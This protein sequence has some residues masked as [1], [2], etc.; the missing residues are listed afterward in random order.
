ME[1]FAEMDS[2]GVGAPLAPGTLVDR[3]YVL[4]EKLGEGG[5]GAVY[6]ATHRARGHVVALKLV[7]GDG[8]REASHIS[9]NT[10]LHKRVG[11]IREFQTLASLHHPNVVRV[12]GYGFDPGLGPYFAMEHL[13]DPETLL[14]AA[15]GASIERKAGL[16]A[17]LLRAIGYL[18]RRGVIHR[19]I[20]PS[21]VL[22]SKGL[23][24]VVDFGVALMSSR[25]THVAGTIEYMAP[26]LLMGAQ[27][28]ESS[29]LYA[30][31]IVAYELFAG[32]FPVG[33]NSM[34]RFLAGVLGTESDPTLPGGIAEIVAARRARAPRMSLRAKALSGPRPRRCR[35]PSGR[36]LRSSPPASKRI[37][38]RGPRMSSRI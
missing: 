15:R 16:L 23:L 9:S 34:T 6:R 22:V 35:R 1:A 3:S 5:M 29:D 32:A 20:K 26:E 28:S 33:K 21:N 36:S 37:A 38:I 4:H 30:V 7:S 2:A 12:Y 17:E 24:K 14:S 19:D 10:A 25:A 8:P 13:E 18:H 11:L 27:P 31:G